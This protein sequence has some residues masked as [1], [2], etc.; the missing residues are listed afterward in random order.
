MKAKGISGIIDEIEN[1]SQADVARELWDIYHELPVIDLA[2]LRLSISHAGSDLKAIIVSVVDNRAADLTD[3][4]ME[5]AATM[6]LEKKLDET[7][8]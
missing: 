1:M 2:Q 7:L 3:E 4:V 8:A 5:K 6:M